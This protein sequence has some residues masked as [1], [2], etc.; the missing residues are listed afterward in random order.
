M[1]YISTSDR[2]KRMLTEHCNPICEYDLQIAIARTHE[3]IFRIT[4]AW[5]E[6]TL[7]AHFLVSHMTPWEFKDFKTNFYHDWNKKRNQYILRPLALEL[8]SYS[9]P[10]SQGHCYLHHREVIQEKVAAH[11][12]QLQTQLSGKKD[13]ID[14][15]NYILPMF[16]KHCQT[17]IDSDS[18]FCKSCGKPVIEN[19]HK[20]PTKVIAEQAYSIIESARNEAQVKNTALDKKSMESAIAL[21]SSAIE[22]GYHYKSAYY[23]RGYAKMQLDMWKEALEDF[24]AA[25]RIDPH[26]SRAISSRQ[27]ALTALDIPDSPFGAPHTVD[28]TG[29]YTVLD[30]GNENAQFKRKAPKYPQNFNEEETP[31]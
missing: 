25:L 21:Y 20:Q 18:N 14:C 7:D 5:G 8:M 26:Y 29:K 9:Y 1:W 16:C 3:E 24:D 4:A 2:K 22:Q 28:F 27:L 11:I 15:S 23:W 10:K 19:Q 12:K 17:T 6:L 13:L 31:F 30:V